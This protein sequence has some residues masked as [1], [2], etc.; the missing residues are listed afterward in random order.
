MEKGNAE[1]VEAKLSK[2]VADKVLERQE[3]LALIDATKELNFDLYQKMVFA[4]E[5]RTDA[6]TVNEPMP[7][8]NLKTSIECNSNFNP[9]LPPQNSQSTRN[10]KLARGKRGIKKGSQFSI[11]SAS[12]NINQ[13]VAM[14]K[15]EDEGE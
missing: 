13:N 6:L 8:A 2:V 12:N 7:Q 14:E 1:L 15:R 10:N 11:D 5:K 9:K 4:G 3:Y